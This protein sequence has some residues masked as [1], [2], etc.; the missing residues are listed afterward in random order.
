M[1]AAEETVYAVL[2][3][4]VS[5]A[6]LVEQD[7]GK[8]RIFPVELAQSISLPAIVYSR[9]STVGYNSVAGDHGASRA[10]IQVDS[11][12]STY[13]QAR[14]LSALVRMALRRTGTFQRQ[15]DLSEPERG[16]YRVSQDFNIHEE[17]W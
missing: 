15:N 3:E 5:I 8:F 17:V 6:A 13:A 14:A 2:T 16:V 11:Y 1:S 10:T 9:V 12:A 7:D 4:D